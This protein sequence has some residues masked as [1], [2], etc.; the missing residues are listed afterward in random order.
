MK[1]LVLFVTIMFVPSVYGDVW[2]VM[3][4]DFMMGVAPNEEDRWGNFLG[5]YID[6]IKLNSQS[7]E[8][9]F[10][11]PG[12]VKVSSEYVF[13]V[14]EPEDR[15]VVGYIPDLHFPLEG[16]KQID[17][18]F[19][20]S[21]DGKELDKDDIQRDPLDTW[22]LFPVGFYEEREYRVIIEYGYELDKGFQAMEKEHRVQ[23][24]IYFFYPAMYWA[25][26]VDGITVDFVFEG[27]DVF[28]LTLIHPTD[29]EFTESGVSW[30]WSNVTEEWFKNDAYIDIKFGRVRPLKSVFYSVFDKYGVEVRELP[31][32]DAPVITELPKGARVYVVNIYEAEGPAG[33]TDFK[34]FQCR[35]LDNTIGYIP[36][37]SKD[38]F[39]LVPL[40]LFEKRDFESFTE[41]N[42]AE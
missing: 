23:G 10:I 16:K 25:G 35:M 37:V 19:R 33:E 40:I 5:G 21:V 13:E 2:P 36:S 9:K 39:T 15:L 26:D 30:E 7:M 31:S 27:G 17:Y 4:G 18:Y 3:T 32:F 24:F 11:T 20:V 38:E 1:T 6:T 42:G 28:D 29:F 12:S 34:W 8:I 14:I 22:F 41:A